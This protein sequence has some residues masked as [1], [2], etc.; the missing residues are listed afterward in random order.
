MKSMLQIS[1][2][3]FGCIIDIKMI[4]NLWKLYLGILNA[5]IQVRNMNNKIR[6]QKY[7]SSA[8][9]CSRRKGEEYIKAGRVR[10][11]GKT[12]I[13]QGVQVN[14]EKDRVEV[15]GKVFR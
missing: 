4:C 8:G 11:N 2:K 14:P 7:L 6:L 12:V 5:I 9:I 10:V 15:D 1:G 3:A 13:E